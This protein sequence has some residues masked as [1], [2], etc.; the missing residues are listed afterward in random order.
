MTVFITA[1]H[2]DDNEI[3]PHQTELCGAHTIGRSKDAGLATE[4]AERRY[5][6]L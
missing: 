1:F 3:V 4:C 2:I 5:D 6:Y